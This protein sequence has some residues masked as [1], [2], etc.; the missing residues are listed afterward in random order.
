MGINLWLNYVQ[1][2]DKFR[3]EGSLKKTVNYLRINSIQHA[4]EGDGLAHVVQAVDPGARI[5]H[6][7]RSE[8]VETEARR[9]L[10]ASEADTGVLAVR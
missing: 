4:G 10:L 1:P 7:C 2:V 5:V 8:A 3:R 9:K 6:E